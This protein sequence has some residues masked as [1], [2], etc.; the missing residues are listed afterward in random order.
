MGYLVLSLVLATIANISVKFSS[1]FER[2]FPSITSFLFFGACLYFLTISV[3]T[4]EVGIAYAIWGGVS[5][6]ATTL[7]GILLFNERASSKKFLFI[8]FIIL[9]IIIIK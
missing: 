7:F 4:I 1:G 9:G 6:M 8:S 2:L 5:I 3:Q